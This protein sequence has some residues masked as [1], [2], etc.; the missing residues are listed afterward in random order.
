MTKTVC[1]FGTASDVGKSVT[2]AAIGRILAR[3][4]L[5]VAPFKAQNMSNNAGVVAISGSVTVELGEI[6]RAQVVQ[7]NACCVTPETDNNPVLLKPSSDRSSQVVLQG[8]VLAEVEAAQLWKAGGAAQSPLRKAA[9]ESLARLQQRFDVIVVEGAG[10]CGE[11]NLRDRDFVN[12]DA[13]HAAGNASVIL[14][15]DIEKGGVFAQ[16]VGTLAVIRPEDRALVKGVVVNK[17]RGDPSLFEDGRVWLEEATGVPILGVIPYFDPLNVAGTGSRCILDAE[18]GLYPGTRVD[19][20]PSPPSPGALP[21]AVVLLPRIANHTDFAPLQAHPNVVLDY[22]RAPRP[23]HGYRVVIIPGSKSVVR[24]LQW[25]ESVGW[26]PELARYAASTA[27]GLLLGVCGGYQMLGQHITD[28][29]GSDGGVPTQDAIPGL[30]LLPVVTDMK[31]RKTLKAVQDG[32]WTCDC[33]LPAG[34]RVAGYE[35]HTGVTS[36]AG[37][38]ESEDVVPVLSQNDQD[39]V[40]A[41]DGCCRAAPQGGAVVLGTYLH[42]LF[43]GSCADAFYTHLTGSP[44]PPRSSADAFDALADHYLKAFSA[45]GEDLLME[46]AR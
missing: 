27:G 3:K 29:A 12:F 45:K 7:A 8:K 9:F 23:L 36:L 34:T 38:G 42:G 30:R 2:A 32:T 13:A 15:A 33:L 5:K 43:D 35:I 39:G 44:S 21:V 41:E 17:F 19:P 28:T 4:G 1:V 14:V 26:L 24:D 22:L 40:A 16:V 37:G 20:P 25:L 6:G 18:D 31:P 46:M 10:S 11:V